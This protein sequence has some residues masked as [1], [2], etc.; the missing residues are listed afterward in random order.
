[1]FLCWYNFPGLHWR[2]T[3]IHSNSLCRGSQTQWR[4]W[5]HTS[6][7]TSFSFNLKKKNNQG[8]S[9]IVLGHSRTQD[10]CPLGK[11]F[12]AIHCKKVHCFSAGP[13]TALP[14]LPRDTLLLGGT[15]KGN[16]ATK[17][18]GPGNTPH[19]YWSL[20]LASRNFPHSKH[21]CLWGQQGESFPSP[22]IPRWA[23]LGKLLPFPQQLKEAPVACNKP[24]K[25]KAP[26]RLW[27]SRCLHNRS[28]QQEARACSPNLNRETACYTNKLPQN[29][30]SPNMTP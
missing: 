26:Q 11:T 29:P 8:N 27:K 12:T 24:S 1:M 14:T 18:P 13:E 16:Q 7:Q 28:P 21:S 22:R 17:S 15:S 2:G 9:W 25:A 5:D 30:L 4:W 10:S 6:Y 20:P 3:S 19:P 23:G